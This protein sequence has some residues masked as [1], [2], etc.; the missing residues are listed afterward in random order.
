MLQR[1]I[2]T[3]T[4]NDEAHWIEV[5]DG[6]GL[7]PAKLLGPYATARLADRAQRGVMRLLNVRR[8]T[9]VVVSQ[10]ELDG[11]HGASGIARDLPS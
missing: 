7:F 5:V 8:Y 6:K 10:R 2:K 4:A 1:S 9:A 3:S 11:R